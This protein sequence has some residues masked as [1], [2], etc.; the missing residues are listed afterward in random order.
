MNNM[1]LF[2]TIIFCFLSASHSNGAASRLSRLKLPESVRVRF[3]TT[4]R[5]SANNFNSELPWEVL[6]VSKDASKKEV[7]NARLA[8]LNKW[9]PDRHTEFKGEFSQKELTERTQKIN[10]AYSSYKNDFWKNMGNDSKASYQYQSRSSGPKNANTADWNRS[11]GYNNFNEQPWYKMKS[12]AVIAATLAAFTTA[13]E[14]SHLRYLFKSI[15]EV[16]PYN[17]EH[18]EHSPYYVLEQMEQRYYRAQDLLD[19]YEGKSFLEKGQQADFNPVDGL[20]TTYK[21]LD[22]RSELEKVRFEILKNLKNNNQLGDND[23]VYK[24]SEEALEKTLDE[25]NTVLNGIKLE[26]VKKSTK[27]TLRILLD[28]LRQAEM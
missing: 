5:P 19:Q 13:L 24:H 14:A 22:N 9:H 3:F 16:Q 11:H 15:P 20:L 6:N 18:F 26:Y 2:Y 4:S 17:K 23:T 8:S 12:R 1:K 27:K 7:E 28:V 25:K 10:E 21:M